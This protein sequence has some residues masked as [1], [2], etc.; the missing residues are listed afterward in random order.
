M[1][2]W[3]SGNWGTALALFYI[4]EK[5]VKLTPTKYDDILVDVFWS[6]IKKALGKK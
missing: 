1:L 3:F 2:E 4:L 6:G 5:L